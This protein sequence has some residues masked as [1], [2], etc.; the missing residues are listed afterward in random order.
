[1]LFEFFNSWQSVMK[2]RHLLAVLARHTQTN[3]DSGY[4]ETRLIPNQE[5]IFNIY[6]RI[7]QAIDSGKPYQTLL[8]PPPA[9]PGCA[10]KSCKNNSLD[11]KEIYRI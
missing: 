1:N 9:D 2:I 8:D 11:Y 10:H 6:D 4:P 7:Q 5:T 3:T